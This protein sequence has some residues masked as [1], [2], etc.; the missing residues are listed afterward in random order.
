MDTLTIIEWVLIICVVVL[1]FGIPAVI[2]RIGTYD[3]RAKA[4][5]ILNKIY[6][7]FSTAL[8]AE[9][10]TSFFLYEMD[11]NYKISRIGMIIITLVM[12]LYTF[13]VKKKN[14]LN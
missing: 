4:I 8:V 10:I 7:L 5:G 12:Y 9:I 13:F 1:Y 11:S 14:W 3:G 6:L 2:N